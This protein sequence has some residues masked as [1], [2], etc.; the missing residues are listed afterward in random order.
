MAEVTGLAAK[1]M[2]DTTPQLACEQLAKARL[3][4]YT[5]PTATPGEAGVIYDRTGASLMALTL[6]G[7]RLAPRFSKKNGRP[8]PLPMQPGHELLACYAVLTKAPE[9]RPEMGFDIRLG[10]AAP[11]SVATEPPAPTPAL[12]RR[13][14]ACLLDAA[15]QLA[16]ADAEQ[17]P[18]SISGRFLPPDGKQLKA[19]RVPRV[20]KSLELE[21]RAASKEL[22][23]GDSVVVNVAV[24]NRGKKNLTY[25]RAD[26]ERATLLEFSAPGLVY[27]GKRSPCTSRWE[28]K[29]TIKPGRETVDAIRVKAES[30]AEPGLRRF[31]IFRRLGAAPA[32]PIVCSQPITLEIKP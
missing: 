25:V 15:Q 20:E 9:L 6:N 5:G 21:A 26:C 18:V 13:F 14:E 30:T 1:A 22:R 16:G 29:V 12:K 3:A 4:V 7:V 17:S 2:E 23:R 11:A 27:G 28:R 31:Q 19:P 10:G 24:R 8:L 32:S